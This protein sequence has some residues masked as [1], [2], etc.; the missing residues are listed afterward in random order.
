MNL[1][2]LHATAAPRIVLG[3]EIKNSP[4]SITP[5]QCASFL[6]ALRTPFTMKRTT[7]FTVEFEHAGEMSRRYFSRKS[8]AFRFALSCGDPE[9]TIYRLTLLGTG[10]RKRKSRR[11]WKKAFSIYYYSD[12]LIVKTPNHLGRSILE[13]ARQFEL[14]RGM[15][16]S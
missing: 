16:K 1:I 14:E 7:Q 5:Y 2:A 12:G 3:A 11:P 8:K 6:R 10:M 9:W 15:P 13:L 4:Y